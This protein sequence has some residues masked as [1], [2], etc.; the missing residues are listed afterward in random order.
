MSGVNTEREKEKTV[1]AEV[2]DWDGFKEAD[3]FE[4]HI[5]YEG[6]LVNGNFHR[7]R[8]VAPN[9]D[10]DKAEGV[11]TVKRRL[12]AN[13]EVRDFEEINKV[14]PIDFKD[15]FRFACD[16]FLCKTRFVF[17]AKS[18]KL[19]MSNGE[20]QEIVEFPEIK[21]EVDVFTNKQGQ[22]LPLAKIDIEIQNLEAYVKEH[23]PHLGD[24]KLR[25]KVSGLP[26]KPFNIIA[27]ENSPEAKAEVDEFWKQARCE[28]E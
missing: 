3:S 23:Y 26:F 17:L 24:Y 15:I 2:G 22:R 4:D 9:G 28:V 13:I 10:V 25:L 8:V 12:S 16:H 6:K 5:Q 18:V 7:F 20:T 27:P 11:Y 14:M 21:Y 1:Y 19:T